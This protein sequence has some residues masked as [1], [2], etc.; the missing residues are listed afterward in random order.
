M[1][2]RRTADPA[3]RAADVADREAEPFWQR[4]GSWDLWYA[5]WMRVY[6]EALQCFVSV[7]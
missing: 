7:A 2:H 3:Q 5:E 1:L 4:T 6:Y